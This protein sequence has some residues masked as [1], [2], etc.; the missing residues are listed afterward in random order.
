MAPGDPRQHRGGSQPGLQRLRAARDPRTA[1]TAG[2]VVFPMFDHG[3]LAMPK[4]PK[5]RQRQAFLPGFELPAW[6]TGKRAP[7]VRSRTSIAAADAIESIRGTV[8]GRVYREIA[9]RGI[10]GATRQEIAEKLELGIP[11][12]CGRFDD[13]KRMNLIRDSGRT[14]KTSSGRAAVVMVAVEGSG[15]NS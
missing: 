3:E 1:R 14:R 9:R 8:N 2:G 7:A 6:Q 11:T 10:N 4:Q 15:G 5:K 13:L 12:V